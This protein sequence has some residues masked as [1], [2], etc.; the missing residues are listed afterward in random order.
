MFKART[1]SSELGGEKVCR[2]SSFCYA[3]DVPGAQLGTSTS[4]S[5]L[6]EPR[7]ISAAQ[8]PEGL[9]CPVLAEQAKNRRSLEWSTSEFGDFLEEL[10]DI[11]WLWRSHS[12]R[13]AA[14]RQGPD[15][16]SK[17]HVLVD[18]LRGDNSL[19]KIWN[20]SLSGSELCKE[21]EE[22]SKDPKNRKDGKKTEATLL[23][24]GEPWRFQDGSPYPASD[25]TE[26]IS[27]GTKRADT[28]LAASACR[29]ETVAPV[30]PVAAP[31]RL[32]SAA[33]LPGHHVFLAMSEQP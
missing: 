12:Q 23:A 24:N 4:F 18:L 21:L 27:V 16:A 29:A 14:W 15:M 32:Q 6:Q 25:L 2:P 33:T 26:L 7:Q 28:W 1:K 22:Q 17:R 30:A 13:R 9:R 3:F 31:A 19:E 8:M 20:E 5:Q 11:S 10:G